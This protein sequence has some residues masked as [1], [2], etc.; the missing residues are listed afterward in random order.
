LANRKDLDN[1]KKPGLFTSRGCL[2]YEA[3]RKML[4]SSTAL[5]L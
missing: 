5:A 1:I 3:Q 4:W 2:R